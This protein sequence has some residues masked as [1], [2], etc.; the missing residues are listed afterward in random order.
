MNIIVF[1]DAG[2]DKLSP[3]S[4]GRPAY[5]ITCGSYRLVDWLREFEGNLVGLV[6]P[7]LETIQLSDYPDFQNQLD[8]ELKWTLVVNAR[9]APTIANV[10]RLQSIMGQADSDQ[11]IQVVR[12]GWATSAAIVPTDLFASSNRESWSK[13]IEELNQ[14]PGSTVTENGFELFDYPHEVIMQNLAC[15]EENLK[16]RI[17]SGIYQQLHKGVYVGNNVQMNDPVIFDSSSGPIIIDD[18]VKIGP[19]TFLRGP[20]YI[21]P[22]TRISEHASIKDGTS[23]SHTCKIGG[24]IEGC[25]VEAYTNKQHH[26]FLGHSYL[27]SWINLGAGTCNSDLKNTYG[28]VNMQYGDEKIATGTQFI[29]CVIGDYSKTAINTCIF[30]GKTIGVASM[31][32]GFA[33]TNV[34]SFVNYARTFGEVGDL[35][36][37]VIIT[38][39]KRMFVRRNV[40]Q[41]PCDIQLVH[42]MYKMTRHER[43]DDLSS[44][45]LSL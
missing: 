31:V 8:P 7:F 12:S 16:H 21:G 34:P 39:Q 32:Y 4:V 15:I 3:I 33:T 41:R 19:F 29:G 22:K 36:A 44:D 20:V 2:T 14:L 30:T 24:E 13:I 43:P 45:P 25:V 27:G 1:E 23:I 11:S 42:D 38:T 37:E 40:A 18:E 35:P 28:I 6:R 5:A 9:L 17:G 26:G 10:R